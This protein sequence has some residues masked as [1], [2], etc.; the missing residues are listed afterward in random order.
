MDTPFNIPSRSDPYT[1]EVV[2]SVAEEYLKNS[3]VLDVGCGTGAFLYK[4][5]DLTSKRFG[6]DFNINQYKENDNKKNIKKVNLD[7]EKLPYSEN[8]FD[9]VFCLDVLEHLFN[10]YVLVEEC[11][12]VLKKDGVFI[13]SSPNL[14]SYVQRIYFLLTGRL[15]GFW[16]K[17]HRRDF[18]E[19][20]LAPIF[21]DQL[22]E[23]LLGRG[24]IIREDF[25][26]SNIPKLRIELKHKSYFMSETVIWTIK[27]I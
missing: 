1:H 22:S 6:C 24:K 19:M 17:K 5:K 12:R 13:V 21:R 11:L 10:P 7:G 9:I 16:D 27:K 23:F 20:H 18:G 14:H 15:K 4:I 8:E 2:L 25:N 26:R 3:N